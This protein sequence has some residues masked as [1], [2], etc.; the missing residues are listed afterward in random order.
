MTAITPLMPRQKVPDLEVA[1]VGG[2][3]WRLSEQTPERF[4]M[5]V[6]YRGWHCP[7]CKGY[8]KDLDNKAA[9]FASK[10]VDILVV[11]SDGQERAEVTKPEWRL[12][13]L[14]VGY[15][16]DLDMAR[17]WGLYISAG[18]G[19]TSLGIEE[20]ALFSEPG[21]FLVRPDGTLYFGAV[22]T[23]P[24]ARPK[25]ADLLLALDFTKARDYP[26]RGEV[27]DHHRLAAE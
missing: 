6:F 16:L 15:G 19:K 7:Q 27:V 5:L 22:Q 24:F 26:A 10:G 9:E 2:G 23:M 3:R 21:L 1:T 17:R 13:H 18:I 12:D 25:F 20:P 14:T 4:T 8:L 11:S